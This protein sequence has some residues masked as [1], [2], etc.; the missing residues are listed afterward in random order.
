MSQIEH[1]IRFSVVDELFGKTGSPDLIVSLLREKGMPVVVAP[2]EGIRAE[3]G[4]FHWED[5]VRG[6]QNRTYFWNDNDLLPSRPRT[7]IGSR[8]T[9]VEVPVITPFSSGWET[10]QEPS[11]PFVRRAHERDRERER[12]RE[13]QTEEIR[14]REY[15]RVTQQFYMDPSWDIS[16]DM[17][18]ALGPPEKPKVIRRKPRA[19]ELEKE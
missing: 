15:A 7:T 4:N 3:R 16:A 9:Q 6:A 5:H 13:Q 10:I 1:T 2:G 8:Q 19:I 12:E 14:Q 11:N 18:A 17:K